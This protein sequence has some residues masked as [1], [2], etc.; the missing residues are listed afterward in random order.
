MNYY[1]YL[2]VVV[3]VVD[4]EKINMKYF[5]SNSPQLLRK[6]MSIVVDVDAVEVTNYYYYCC[7][8]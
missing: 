6:M 4:E 7:F 8:E 2:D 1:N 5:C 3:V